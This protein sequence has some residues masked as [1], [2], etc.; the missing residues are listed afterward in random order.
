MKFRQQLMS[1]T[2]QTRIK[3]ARETQVCSETGYVFMEITSSFLR[4]F[5]LFLKYTVNIN[6]LRLQLSLF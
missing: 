4:I 5:L 1:F 3:N 6:G 2:S